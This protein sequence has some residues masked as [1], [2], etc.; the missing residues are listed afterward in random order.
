MHKNARS[1]FPTLQPMRSIVAL[2]ANLPSEVGQPSATLD[3]AVAM[4][5]EK[6]AKVTKYSHWFATPAWP[7]GGGPDY[8]NGAAV[9]EFAGSALAL[10]H[11]LQS[12]ETALG[13]VRL[14]GAENRWSARVCDIDLLCVGAT[15][16][17]GLVTW[18]EAAAMAPEEPLP[19][20]VLPHPRLHSRVFVLAPMAEIAPDWRHPVLGKTVA[21][22]LAEMPESARLSVTPQEAA[23]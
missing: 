12:V 20:L 22:M 23:P 11:I 19:E 17:P 14:A 18:R 3:R 15:V 1:A 6:G 8:T 13:R 7:P 9:I 4:L 10:L 5:S 16:S 21:E 2:G